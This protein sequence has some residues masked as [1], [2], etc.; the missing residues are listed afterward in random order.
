MAKKELTTKEKRTES[1]K[2]ANRYKKYGGIIPFL[3]KEYDGVRE[4]V[5]NELVRD[6]LPPII[7]IQ[8]LEKNFPSIP[9]EHLPKENAVR[10]YITKTLTKVEKKNGFSKQ[11]AIALSEEVEAL[12]CIEGFSIIKKRKLLID[13]IDKMMEQTQIVIDQIMQLN[14]FGKKDKKSK[15]SEVPIVPN[16]EML[17][18]AF[19][20]MS[21]LLDREGN[22]LMEMDKLMVRMGLMPEMPKDINFNQNNINFGG[23]G[24]P[25]DFKGEMTP[26][27][28]DLMDYKFRQIYWYME[29]KPVL[30]KFADKYPLAKAEPTDEEEAEI[31]NEN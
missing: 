11:T 6:K 21:S 4:F 7:F 28:R 23:M 25:I 10:E 29:R 26:E 8:D 19:E 18:R 13:K 20:M 22:H 9:K 3:C 12:K 5:Y 1:F 15:K 31:E 16:Y 17:W 24:Q 14:G 2:R 27:I 30:D